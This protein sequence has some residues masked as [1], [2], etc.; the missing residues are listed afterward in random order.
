[1][2]TKTALLIAG[3]IW[4]GAC[5]TD[6]QPTV[7][8]VTASG[9][10]QTTTTTT[11]SNEEAYLDVIRSRDTSGLVDTWSDRDLIEVGELSCDVLDQYAPNYEAAINDLL[12]IL[13]SEPGFSE[14]DAETIGFVMGAAA[15]GLCPEH[16]DGLVNAA[17]A[18]Y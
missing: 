6:P 11:I 12:T 9:T 15:R 3:L 10:K 1:M 4:L 14:R 16:L 2:K 18:D 8:P 7:T 17:S 5:S 13:L